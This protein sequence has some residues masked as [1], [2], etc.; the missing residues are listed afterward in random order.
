LSDERLRLQTK[1]R[2]RGHRGAVR[3]PLLLELLELLWANLDQLLKLLELIRHQLQQL[4]KVSQLLLL[5]NLQLLQL[6]RHD[7]QQLQ[8]VRQGGR[9]AD[10]VSSDRLIR[11]RCPIPNVLPPMVLIRPPQYAC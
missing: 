3:L 8:E 10:S 6:L 9:R 11:E 5:E 7:L 1:A 4:L 2:W